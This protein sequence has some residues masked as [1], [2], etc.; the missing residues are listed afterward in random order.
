M[1]NKNELRKF[2]KELRQ[3]LDREKISARILQI[4]LE[5]DFYKKATNIAIYYPFQDEFDFTQLLNNNEKNWFLPK[6][7]N[8]NNLSFHKYSSKDILTPNKYGILEPQTQIA[9]PQKLDLIIMPALVTDKRGYRIGYG[10]GYYDNFLTQNSINC[11]KLIFIA[12]ELVVEKI[13]NDFWDIRANAI[14]TQK[15]LYV[16]DEL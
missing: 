7:T 11:T 13:E 5:T 4:F 2:A 1:Q 16:F 12:E 9:D 3:N 8:D 14:I 10:K 6:I 15:N